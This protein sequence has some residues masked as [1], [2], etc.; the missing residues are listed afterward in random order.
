M[1][2]RTYSRELTVSRRPTDAINLFTPRGE[3]DWVPG[4]EPSYLSPSTGQTQEGMVFTTGKDEEMTFW[5]CLQWRPEDGHARYLRIT[6]ASRFAYV[7]VQ[8]RPDG[9]HRTRVQVS[10]EIHALTV[11]G[12][13][14]LEAFTEDA[15]A[16][17]ID[18]WSVLIQRLDR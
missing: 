11:A 10:Y 3:E 12:T 13:S 2:H 15:F 8:C 17:M 4:W 5:T 1:R 7:D 18:E 16:A 6:P 9:E 14:W